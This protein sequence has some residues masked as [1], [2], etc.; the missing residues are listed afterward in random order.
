[1]VKPYI[2]S[3]QEA[4]NTKR[5]YLRIKFNTEIF[6]NLLS[7]Q[8]QITVPADG[9]GIT[10]GNPN[11]KHT[12][13]KV[14]NPYCGPCSK[15][16]SKIEELLHETDAVKLKII[17]TAPNDPANKMYKPVNH[18]LAIQEKYA[19][20]NILKEALDRW[21]LSE[22]KDYDRFAIQYPMNGELNKQGAK[23][24]AMYNW[25]NKMEIMATPTI[26]IDGFQL[27]DAYDVKDLKY[28]LQE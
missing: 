26:F 9:L 16:H 5:E 19:S 20:E 24:E 3:L 4:K 6:E 28:F 13:V 8:K 15:M 25:C 17:F 11:A 18:L 14:C 23:V 12:L 2:L 7:K 21:Y 27:P 1:V 22:D 10:L